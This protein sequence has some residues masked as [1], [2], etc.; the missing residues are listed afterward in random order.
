MGCEGR[1]AHSA[2]IIPFIKLRWPNTHTYIVYSEVS[3]WRMNLHS[4]NNAA[5]GQVGLALY[6]S[7]QLEMYKIDKKNKTK[8]DLFILG[9]VSALYNDH[10]YWV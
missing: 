3:T 4:S 8:N 6:A 1:A 2:D 5:T 7:P 10:L 9:R